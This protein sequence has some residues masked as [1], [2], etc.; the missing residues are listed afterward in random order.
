MS[1]LRISVSLC[2]FQNVGASHTNAISLTGINPAKPTQ[3]QSGKTRSTSSGKSV[4]ESRTAK[5]AGR[6]S[7]V[8]PLV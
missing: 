4:L 2:L 3:I 1:L 5:K 8:S 7:L 6:Y